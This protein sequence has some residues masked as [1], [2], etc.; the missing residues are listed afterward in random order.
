VLQAKI[1]KHLSKDL[2][3]VYQA[4]SKVEATTALDILISTWETKYPLA[5]NPWVNH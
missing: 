2:K 5:V 3:L 1:K 4:S